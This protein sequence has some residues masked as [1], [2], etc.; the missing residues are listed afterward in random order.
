M[1][2]CE[3]RGY[4]CRSIL[5]ED[6]LFMETQ[7][8]NPRAG[9]WLVMETPDTPMHVGVLAIFSLPRGAGKDFLAEMA[10]EFRLHEDVAAPWN[11]VLADSA[12]G[13]LLPKVLVNADIE[14]DY[15]FRHSALPLPGGEREL[16]V[17]VSRLHSN[18]LDRS[19]PLWE[20][21]LIEGLENNRFAFYLKVHRA[22]IEDINAVGTMLSLLSGSA[23]SRHLPPPWTQP[24][25]AQR[26]PSTNP[27]TALAGAAGSAGR[28]G[29]GLLRASFGGSGSGSV[30]VPNSAPRSTLNRPISSR[31]RFATWQLD[32]R[33]IERLA[34]ATDSTVNEI[35]SYLCGSSLRRFF[36]EY[37][38]LPDE[39]LVGLVPVSLKERGEQNPGGAVTGLR[40]ELG[41]HIGNPL[42]RL[43][44][45]KESVQAVR[46]DRESLPEQAA[47]PYA[48]M[49]A[50]PLIASQLRPLGRLVPPLFNLQVSMT[51]G[52]DKPVYFNGARL[53]ALYPLTQLLQFTALSIDCVSYAGTLNFGFT[54]ARETLPHLQRLAVYLGGALEDLEELTNTTREA[55]V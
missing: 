2:V 26:R 13:G 30:L 19:R 12:L 10:A 45:V 35:L 8:V 39:S 4:N 27:L 18:G 52:P 6:Y 49:R 3:P 41:T 29:L 48:L 20:F 40:V 44:A 17:L 37:N 7:R 16:G 5:C 53:E 51:P 34:A 11:W 1:A 15:H 47:T 32:Q 42:A 28:A 23:R 22:L 9:A 50:A 54:G 24:L 25:E 55:A 21:H 36:K 43:A 31:R 46:R 14:L 38:A 33:R